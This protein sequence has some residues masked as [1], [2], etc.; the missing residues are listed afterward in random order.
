MSLANV[1]LSFCYL[2]YFRYAMIPLKML[3]VISLNVTIK[4][5]IILKK[6]K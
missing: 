4:F 1:I 2:F 3:A 5:E 6:G